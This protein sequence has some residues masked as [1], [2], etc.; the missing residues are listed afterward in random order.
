MAHTPSI[1]ILVLFKCPLVRSLEVLFPTKSSVPDVV[2]QAVVA[3]VSRQFIYHCT[4]S[5]QNGLVSIIH[6][7]EKKS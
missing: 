5:F 1:C 2:Y 4:I 6:V 3:V 7:F